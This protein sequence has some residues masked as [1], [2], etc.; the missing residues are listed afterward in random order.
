[1]KVRIKKMS[2][3]AVIP[4]YSK[5][6]DIGLDL[7]ATSYYRVSDKNYGYI[8]Y[9]TGLQIEIP[10]GFG[11][12]IFPRSSISNTGMILANAVGV[13]DPGYR[14]EVKCRFRWIKD[15][16]DYKVGDRVAQLIILPVPHVD[17][18]E[19]ESLTET[20]RS[21]AGFGSTN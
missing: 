2:E 6:G 10:E 12:F 3:S 21:E 5:P 18:V 11:G 8:E 9:G 19:A 4:V 17:L 20:V 7:T 14:G 16:L 1:M 15:T 13:I